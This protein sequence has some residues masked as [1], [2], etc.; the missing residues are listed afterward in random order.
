[1]SDIAERLRMGLADRYTLER[2]LGAGGMA[3]V[4][5]AQDA[6][7]HRQVALKVMRPELA[8][9]AERFLREI[10]I[11]ANLQHPNILA[12][13]D[14]GEVDN[15]LYYVMPYVEGPSL[16]ERLR[17]EGELPVGEAVR[18]LHD[19]ADALAAAHAKGV[20][21]RDIK[22]ENILLSGRHAL[23]ADFGVA[24]AVSESTDRGTLTSMGVALGT[25]AY[26]AP[27]QGAADP[28]LDHRA[29]LYAFGVVAYE[30]VAGRPPFER[31]SP[32]AVLLAHL[33]EAPTPIT[34]VRE[35]LPLPL[36]QLIMRCLEKKAADRPQ[37]ADE[38]LTVL[39][40]LST[41]TGGITPTQTQPVKAVRGHRWALV[42]AVAS[43]VVLVAVA[44][45]LTNRLLRAG[46]LHI[47]VSDLTQVTSEPVLQF[48]PTVSPDGKEVAYLAGPITAP[49]L[50]IRS[51]VSVAGGEVRLADTSAGGEWY[52]AW[53]ADGEFVRYSGCR[54]GG[55]SDCTER[56][57]G[58]MGGGARSYTLPRDA[59]EPA[60]SS[61]GRRVAF[62]RGD[63]ILT[64]S[65]TDTVEHRVAVR[66]SM[67]GLHSLAW[68]P[69]GRRIAFVAGNPLWRTTGN[70]SEASIWTVDAEGGEPQQVTPAGQLNVSPA[71]LDA[72]HLLFV[73]NRDGPQR[74]VYV[75]EVGA[76][77]SRGEPQL[78]AGISDP[79]SISYAVAAKKIAWSKFIQRQN[80]WAYPLNGQVP[81]SIRDGRA[82]T[83]G[84]QV[85]EAHDISPDDK[86]I[87]FDSGRRGN[88]D[89]FRMAL[90]GGDPVPLTDAP[91][92]EWG[93]RWSP[94]GTEIAFYAAT[95]AGAT[96]IMV[97]PANGGTPATVTHRALN[98]SWPT[99][100]PDGLQLDFVSCGGG[101]TGPG[102][103]ANQVT[104]DS[105]AGRWSEPARLTE[106][107]CNYAERA[108]A[109]GLLLCRGDR[110][111]VSV[112]SA[113]TGRVQVAD[114]AAAN[115]LSAMRLERFSLDGKTVYA[116]ATGPDGRKGIWAI[117]AAGGPSR[118]VVA[119][120]DPTL[121]PSAFLSVGREYL[122][123]TISEYESDIWVATL[124]Y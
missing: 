113:Q 33:T 6:K 121:V 84:N 105:V 88:Q 28:H 116:A 85:V 25:P 120:D 78:I 70:V 10:T 72:R 82:V 99:W 31:D 2:E 89:I 9:T 18:I 68:S 77:G 51:T 41:P 107:R 46:P 54:G 79:H 103:P 56:E 19:V 57:T 50:V 93:P 75:V 60:W 13:F 23:V 92:D 43:G 14:S 38:I 29:D 104:R 86:W 65:T 98:D 124:R 11:A 109:G 87:A 58:R 35:K 106:V 59:R 45:L 80:V 94:D 119:Y 66:K 37:S 74:G 17:K 4:Y 12:V 39:E 5:L 44:G 53:S 101:G 102:C 21:H 67:L 71:W 112:L 26:M 83:T 42:A 30:M 114:F 8:A 22:P 100:S 108:P 27:E 97:V 90:S 123:V 20:V 81:V 122:Y 117:P 76:E 34:E 62:V 49:H 110:G 91:W 69:D 118:L 3:T 61:D 111:R 32:Q 15:L 64:A 16:R 95:P 40:T 73:S 55:L 52:P 47:T 1:V 63:T 24:K 36:A 48:Q 96:S 115:H 7:H